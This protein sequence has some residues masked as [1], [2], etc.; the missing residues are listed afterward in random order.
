MN[1][2]L[3][4]QKPATMTRQPPLPMLPGDARPIGDA[5]GVCE[6]DHGGVVFIWGNAAFAWDAGDRGARRFAAVQFVATKTARSSQVARTFGV[7]TTTLW[8]WQC[9]FAESGLAGL[10]DQKK[11]PKSQ[12][13]VTEQTATQPACAR[14]EPPGDRQRGRSVDLPGS[15]GARP[16]RT[17]QGAGCCAG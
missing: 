3:Q 17:V 11:G 1:Q 9:D 13:K 2:T 8:R 4:D 7:G 15:P 6:Y 10:I 16:G 5:A 14:R 12:R